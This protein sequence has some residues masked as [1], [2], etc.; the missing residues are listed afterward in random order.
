MGKQ[1]FFKACKCPV[2]VTKIVVATNSTALQNLRFGWHV[3]TRTMTSATNTVIEKMAREQ[4]KRQQI[5]QTYF[6][7]GLLAY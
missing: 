2:T 7:V 1:Y 6:L 5:A 3:F 4:Q